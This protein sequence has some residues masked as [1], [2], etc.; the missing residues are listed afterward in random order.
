MF[1]CAFNELKSMF[2]TQKVRLNKKKNTYLV[3]KN[4]NT[5]KDP[6]KFKNCQNVLLAKT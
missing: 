4:E 3:K 2:N 6:K 5:F 1:G